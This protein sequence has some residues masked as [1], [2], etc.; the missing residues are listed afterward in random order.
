[1]NIARPL[2]PRFASLWSGLGPSHIIC[3][4]STLL[5]PLEAWIAR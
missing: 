5:F 2:V 1:M 4:L 3:S